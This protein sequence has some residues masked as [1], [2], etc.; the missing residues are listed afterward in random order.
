MNATLPDPNSGE[1]AHYRRLEALYRSAPVNE[2][3]ESTLAIREAGIAEI[4]FTIDQAAFHA[5]GAAQSIT[6][7]ANG[8]HAQRV[9]EGQ[10]G[11]GIVDG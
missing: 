6:I 10:V 4:R 1:S 7:L 9:V 8:T 5:A 11:S 2:L 3:F